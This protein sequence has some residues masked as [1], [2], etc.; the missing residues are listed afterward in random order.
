MIEAEIIYT[1]EVI[2][3]K[4]LKCFIYKNVKEKNGEVYI[5]TEDNRAC[6]WKKSELKKLT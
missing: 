1:H 3:F 5:R 6:W 4:K 2:W